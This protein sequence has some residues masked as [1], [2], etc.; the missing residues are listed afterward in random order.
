MAAQ[1]HLPAVLHHCQY[2]F[3]LFKGGLGRDG[4]LILFFKSG[5][6]GLLF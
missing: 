6:E 1:F 5:A 2:L 3:L 4:V